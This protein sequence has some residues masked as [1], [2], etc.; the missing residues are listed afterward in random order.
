MTKRYGLTIQRFYLDDGVSGLT[1][2]RSAFEHL[3]DD[4][5]TG[6]VGIVVVTSLD[7]LSRNNQ[8]ATLVLT[9]FEGLDVG[10]LIAGRSSERGK[11]G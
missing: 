5:R 7:R 8:L 9:T 10:V 11:R 3:L 6:R 1:L 4:S 2:K